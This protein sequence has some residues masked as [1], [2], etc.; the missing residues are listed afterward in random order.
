MGDLDPRVLWYTAFANP[1]GILVRTPEPHNAMRVLH[2]AREELA[3]S[4]LDALELR[5]S[6][7]NPQGEV[8]IINPGVNLNAE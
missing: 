3:D 6:V 2:L 4:D 1:P 7:T 5:V 8:W